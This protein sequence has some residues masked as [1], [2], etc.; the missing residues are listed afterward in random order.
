[1]P[2]AAARALPMAKVRE[3]VRSAGTP[4]SLAAGRLKEMARMARD[5]L[6]IDRIHRT[7]S[8]PSS[9]GLGD[10]AELLRREQPLWIE[11]VKSAGIKPE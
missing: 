3:I 11:A 8:D 4:M 7:G 10:F 9:I 1:M 5:P 2:P 6:A